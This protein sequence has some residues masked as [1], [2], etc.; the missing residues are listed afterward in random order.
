MIP[1]LADRFSLSACGA[2]S[3]PGFF[4][5]DCSFGHGLFGIAASVASPPAAFVLSLLFLTYELNR[6]KT[7]HGRLS[8]LA[9]YG[10]GFLVG[11]TVREFK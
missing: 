9:E 3:A 2:H 10:T 5:S 11:K 1:T 4:S 7:P 8:A 6:S